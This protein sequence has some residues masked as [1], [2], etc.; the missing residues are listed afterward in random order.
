MVKFLWPFVI[1]ICAVRAIIMIVELQRGCVTFFQ[2]SVLLS[3]PSL[4]FPTLSRSAPAWWDP[5]AVYC[6]QSRNARFFML[7]CYVS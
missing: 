4:K 3:F 1:I 6:Y 7:L 5:E 2:C